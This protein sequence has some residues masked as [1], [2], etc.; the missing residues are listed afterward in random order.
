MLK[1][2]VDIKISKS[3]KTLQMYEL[4]REKYNY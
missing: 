3:N 1:I 2:D 4:Y